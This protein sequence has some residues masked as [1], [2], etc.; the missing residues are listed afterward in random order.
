MFDS[1][2]VKRNPSE[3]CSEAFASLL[4]SN[5]DEDQ[6]L[7]EQQH[8]APPVQGPTLTPSDHD[9]DNDTSECYS[10]IEEIW[11]TQQFI[12][13]LE[14]AEFD[15]GDLSDETIAAISDPPKYSIKLNPEDDSDNDLFM[16]LCLFLNACNLA[17]KYNKAIG[18]IQ[19]WF[20]DSNTILSYY[21][22]KW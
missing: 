16:C 14:N 11:I 20:G 2:N 8:Q 12:K 6:G 3:G 22:L 15:N 18:A 10:N 9:H 4:L 21:Q 17:N 7:Q 13:V 5:F 1:N 19:Q